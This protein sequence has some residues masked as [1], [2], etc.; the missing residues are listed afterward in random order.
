MI[1]LIIFVIIVYTIYKLFFSKSDIDKYKVTKPN[2]EYGDNNIPTVPVKRTK[3]RKTV[4]KPKQ[5]QPAKRVKP[6]P[7]KLSPEE[8]RKRFE[9]KFECES[10]EA[11][12]IVEIP[13][14]IDVCPEDGA[15]LFYADAVRDMA[16]YNKSL[17]CPICNS[18]FVMKPDVIDCRLDI[19]ALYVCVS[20]K[21]CAQR[22][23]KVTSVTIVL[24]NMDLQPVNIN[25]QYC[26]VCGECFISNAQYNEEV[27]KY[28]RLLG[29]I[30]FVVNLFTKAMP[31]YNTVKDSLLSAN[32]YHVNKI[33]N[34]SQGVR[35]KILGYILDNEILTKPEVVKY[36]SDFI[37]NAK[38]R[39]QANMSQA[40]AR[41]EEDLDWVNQYNLEGQYKIDLR[42]E[43]KN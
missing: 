32:G 27:K 15:P 19:S 41:W 21:Q 28:G 1:K 7:I 42:G 3:R 14:A 11:K 23:H 29:K 18:V 30:V 39:R 33:L 43:F 6:E 8:I 10:F 17:C 40:I 16:V 2:R 35:I 37:R 31:D 22:K 24:S 5:I 36:L 13:E 12:K 20:D 4:S 25:A 38:K 26:Y 9:K 34:L